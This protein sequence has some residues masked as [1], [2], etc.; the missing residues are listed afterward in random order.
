MNTKHTPGP[1][2]IVSAEVTPTEAGPLHGAVGICSVDGLHVADVKGYGSTPETNTA[3]ARLIAAAPELRAAL[4]K[5]AAE[6]LTD[7]AKARA[8]AA[9]RQSEYFF[10]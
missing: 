6:G 3:N 8:R 7:E 5:I 1:W 2:H 10:A 4:L 9:L